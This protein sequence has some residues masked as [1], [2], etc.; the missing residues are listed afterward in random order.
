MTTNA[1]A[2]LAGQ[3]MI[4]G[5]T[6]T[7]KFFQLFLHSFITMSFD[8]CLCL[9]RFNFCSLSRVTSPQRAH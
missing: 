6:A 2:L 7:Q 1:P 4:E 8:F 3:R 5:T 9:R